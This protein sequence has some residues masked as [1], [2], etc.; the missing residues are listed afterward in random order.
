MLAPRWSARDVIYALGV[1]FIRVRY[2][3]S[4]WLFRPPGVYRPQGDTRL[5]AEALRVVRVG[6]RVLDVGTGTGVLALAAARGGATQSVLCGIEATV[7]RLRSQ[8]LRTA[9]IARRQEPFGPLLGKSCRIRS[10]LGLT[11]S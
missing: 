11:E 4:V 6:S 5:L 3:H 8:R 10:L 7:E 9:V 1:L 2:E